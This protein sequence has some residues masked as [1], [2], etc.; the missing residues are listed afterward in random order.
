MLIKSMYISSM[1]RMLPSE[2]AARRLG[3]KV[4]TLYAYVSRGLLASHPEPGGK[5]SLFELADIEALA[6]RQ[7][8]GRQTESRLA[9]VTTSVT[10][11][12]DGG[13]YY[14]GVAAPDLVGRMSYEEVA[15]LL[16]QT[17]E[18][19]DWSTPDIGRCPMERVG[20]RMSWAIL[21]CGAQ[22]E[23]RADV[24]PEAVRAAARRIIAALTSVVGDGP[25]APESASIAGRLAYGLGGNAP[26]LSAEAVNAA[27]ILMADHELATST[28]AVRVAASTRADLYDAIAA[29]LA[30]VAGPLHGLASQQAYE[31][32]AT[33]ER[34]GAGPALN[35]ALR[36]GSYLP[37]FG[38]SIYKEFDPRCAPLLAL[39]EPQLS[40]ERRAVLRDV[41]DLAQSRGIPA[42]NCDLALAALTWGTDM[43]SDAG[44]TIFTVARIAG[45]TA[46]YQEELAERPLRF[47]VRALYNV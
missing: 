23:L 20:D 36:A 33:A 43:A 39:A 1:D 29:G 25:R 26:Q 47:R 12:R 11:L 38:H 30:T 34:D 18:V 35:N 45:W 6:K 3:V 28:L 37:G 19:G 31:L 14:R 21:M 9:T 46:H 8:G 5:R 17:D 40:A 16:W 15:S 13:P 41:L 32:L 2:E 44:R 7:R 42:A 10:Q 4:N 27:L 24:R 22:D